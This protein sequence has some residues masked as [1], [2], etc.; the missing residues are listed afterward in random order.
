MKQFLVLFVPLMLTACGPMRYE[1]VADHVK[2]CESINGQVFYKTYS[3]NKNVYD[4]MCEVDGVRYD[5][6]RF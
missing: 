6:N 5:S 3:T 4:V 1:D 2:R